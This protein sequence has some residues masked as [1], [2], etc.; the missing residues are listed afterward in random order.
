MRKLGGLQSESA[1]TRVLERGE[2]SRLE[3]RDADMVERLLRRAGELVFLIASRQTW[4]PALVCTASLWFPLTR[5][6][7]E[8]AP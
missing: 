5:C 6:M 2:V 4:S 8:V 7:T 1:H 3:S